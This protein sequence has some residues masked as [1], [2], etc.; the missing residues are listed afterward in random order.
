MAKLK[1]VLNHAGMDE[2]LKSSGVRQVVGEMAERVQEVADTTKPNHESGP[3]TYFSGT[4]MG[5]SRVSAYVVARHVMG[6]YLESK[7]RTLGKALRGLKG[8]N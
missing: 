5:R 6:P 4:Q 8:A 1:I 2:L 7:Y 3:V